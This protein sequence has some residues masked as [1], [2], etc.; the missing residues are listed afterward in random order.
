[1][2]NLIPFQ[3][4]DEKGLT[5]VHSGAISN[6]CNQQ[7]RE[8][9]AI[10][11]SINNHSEKL[12][13]KG[14]DY[15][16]V[17]A[18]FMPVNIIELIIRKGELHSL[19]AF[20][21]EGVKAKDAM[22]SSLKRAPFEY[23]DKAPDYPEM[24]KLIEGK[25]FTEQD[26]LD[27]FS[28]EQIG[29][30]LYNESIAA[31]IGRFIHDGGKLSQLRKEL[32]LIPPTKWHSI[33]KDEQTPVRVTKHHSASQLSAL[34]EE[35]AGLHRN[36]EKRVNY[37]KALIL[38]NVA[39][40]NAAEANRV[41]LLNSEIQKRNQNKNATHVTNWDNWSTFRQMAQNKFENERE[42]QIK[43]TAQLRIMIP[44][45]LQPMV[46]EFMAKLEDR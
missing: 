27:T 10:I 13:H 3:I 24:D 16:L 12:T 9:D 18:Y 41:A 38:N 35:L 15:N 8:I 44:A 46:D 34:H 30:Y 2:K 11:A 31:H 33:I 20:L 22:L 28:K 39:E 43:K 29:E 14:S 23:E 5:S 7:A 19:Q 4:L 32:P 37:Y 42:Q 25:E 6:L 26:V 36:A 17:D 45:E 40:M 1:M 21:M